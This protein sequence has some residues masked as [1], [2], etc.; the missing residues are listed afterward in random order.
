MPARLTTQP[1]AVSGR[2]FG[3]QGGCFGGGVGGLLPRYAWGEVVGV[4]GAEFGLFVVK[5]A[6]FGDR[7][8]GFEVWGT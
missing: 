6:R 3:E 2:V 7:M 5:R 8:G 4:L 1:A